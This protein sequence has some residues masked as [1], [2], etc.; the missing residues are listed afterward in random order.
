MTAC[1]TIEAI[2]RGRYLNNYSFKSFFAVQHL[3]L[4]PSLSSRARGQ[5]KTN[6]RAPCIL[7]RAWAVHLARIIY[8]RVA[9]SFY[10][11]ISNAGFATA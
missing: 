3:Q 5:I 4:S 6:T 2:T 8:T 11:C 1:T 10:L 9:T 7:N